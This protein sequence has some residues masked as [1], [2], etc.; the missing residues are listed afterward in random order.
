MRMSKFGRL[1]RSCLLGYCAARSD[2]EYCRYVYVL[3]LLAPISLYSPYRKPS[4][5][6]TEPFRRRDTQH[7]VAGT[8]VAWL[9]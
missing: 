5:L 2:A 9:R 1:R 7:Q 6:L 4:L 3:S 8:A